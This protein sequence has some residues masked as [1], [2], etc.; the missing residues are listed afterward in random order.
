MAEGSQKIQWNLFGDTPRV[1]RV[2]TKALRLKDL[3]EYRTVY[4]GQRVEFICHSCWEVQHG[5]PAPTQTH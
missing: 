2:C 4:P 5:R 1:C 3:Q